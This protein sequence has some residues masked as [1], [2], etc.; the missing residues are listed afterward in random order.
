MMR[1]GCLSTLT[2]TRRAGDGQSE[3]KRERKREVKKEGAETG[4]KTQGSPSTLT[5]LSV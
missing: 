2:I 1:C 5:T 4:G 3:V